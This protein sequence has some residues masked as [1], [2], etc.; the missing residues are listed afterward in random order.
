MI[1]VVTGA[2]APFKDGSK[3]PAEHLKRVLAVDDLCY[4]ISITCT[5]LVSQVF[6]RMGFDDKEIVALSGA[7][8]LGRA[9]KN[10]SGFGAEVR[11]SVDNFYLIHL[12][13]TTLRYAY[14]S[15]FGFYPFNFVTDLLISPPCARSRTCS[16][17]P[18][19]LREM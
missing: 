1:I 16:T 6:Y 15:Y 11:N 19:T 8:T 7:H 18:S 14:G 2:A 3:S 4:V 10:R 5:L 17:V 9:F 13:H 12:Y